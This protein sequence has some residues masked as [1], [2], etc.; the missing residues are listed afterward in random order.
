MPAIEA[1]YRPIEDVT[2]T[3]ALREYA[4]EEFGDRIVIYDEGPF[5]VHL[6]KEKE[7]AT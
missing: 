4:E 1:I 7:L 3:D 6:I 2:W 5:I